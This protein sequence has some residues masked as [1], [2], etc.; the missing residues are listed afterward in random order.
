MME[1]W[2]DDDTKQ[3][4][5]DKVRCVVE[6]YG[7]LRSEEVNATVSALVTRSS[8][9]SNPGHFLIV[10]MQVNGVLTQSENI[11]DNAAL[12]LAYRAYHR[13]VARHGPEAPV[14][15]PRAPPRSP[16]EPTVLF[17]DSPSLAAPSAPPTT[18]SPQLPPLVL[19]PSQMF[20][21]SFAS[22]WCSKESNREMNRK[23]RTSS[24]LPGVHRVNGAVRNQ[25]A[26]AAD[27]KCP[28]GS[29][30]NPAH[31]CQVW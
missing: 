17:E 27:F 4:F 23:L 2:W 13:Y 18:A 10:L 16:E 9:D 6:L 26:F 30:M 8:R 19:Q 29:P 21:L 20:W 5:D 24:H 3:R 22:V 15:L 28:V 14:E 25:E 1:D 12:K 31:K 7:R 11:A